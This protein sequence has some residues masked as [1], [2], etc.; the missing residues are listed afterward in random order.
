MSNIPIF[1]VWGENIP[2]AWEHS[3]MKVYMDGCEISTQ[4]DKEGDP[5]S[6]DCTMIIEILDP[7]SEPMIHKD[8]PGGYEDLQEYTMEVLDGIKDHYIRDPNN[9]DDT[10]WEY[11]YHDRLTNYKDEVGSVDQIAIMCEQLAKCGYTRR[12]QAITW[13]PQDDLFCSDP[14]CLQ[15]IW[16][17]VIDDTLNMNVHMRS[18]DAYKANMMN[19]YA[20]VRLQERIAQE[21]SRISG[22]PIKVGRYCHIADSYHIYGSNLKEFEDRFIKMMTARSFNSR[23]TRYVDVKDIMDGAVPHI[24]NKIG[25]V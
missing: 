12:A 6:K 7:L 10:R 20:F 8:M 24:M 5:P 1:Q 21:I 18:N 16:A 13:R 15:R 14:A 2:Q 17:R 22:K 9:P 19:M 3:L 11:T 23:T 25:A 4:Y